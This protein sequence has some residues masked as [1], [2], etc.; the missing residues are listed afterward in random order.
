MRHTTILLLFLLILAAPEHFA[1]DN[2]ELESVALTIIGKNCLPCHNADQKTAGLVLD[3]REGALKGGNSGPALVPLHSADSLLIKK[4]MAGQMPPGN[5]LSIQDREILRQWVEAGA[6]WSEPLAKAPAKRPRGDMNWWAFQ[7]LGKP[8]VPNPSSIPN[9]WTHTAI[10]RFIYTKLRE[11]GLQPS[12]P[13]DRT[14]L[15]RRA[16]YDLLGLPPTPEEVDTFVNDNSPAAYEKLVDRL[17]NSP[18]YGERWGR[19]WLDVIRFGESQGYE[20][21]H[22][23]EQAWPFRDYIIKSFNQDKPFT[24]LIL[25]QLAGDQIAP[26]DPEIAVGTGFLVAGT[27]DTVTIENIEGKLQ[28]RANDLDDMVSTTGAAFL[29]VTIGC[30]RC[31]DHKFDP[32]QQ[33]DYYR[34]QAAFG[35]VQHGEREWTTLGL[36]ERRAAEEK[37]LLEKQQQVIAK[38]NALKEQARP[39]V[40]SQTDEITRRLRPA[41][42]SRG[43]E[44]TFPPVAARFVRMTILATTKNHPPALD[45]LEIWTSGPDPK[46]VA[47]ASYGTKAHARKTRTDEKDPNFYK[48]E[49]L[50]D[51]KA[52]EIW[53]SGEK[54][55]GEVTF[56]FPELE[57]ISRIT[58]S[59]DRP[60]ANQGK[61]VGYLPIHYTFE[62]STDGL[63]WQEISGSEDRLPYDEEERQELFILAVLPASD[64]AAWNTLK[65]EKAELQEALAALPP[66]SQAYIGTFEQPHEPAYLLKRGNPMDKGQVIPPGSLSTLERMLPG[67]QLDPNTPEGGRRLALAR[68]ISDE[69]NAL[70][71]RVL[72]NRVWHYHFG[73]G[74][75]GTPS[76][77]GFNGERPTHPELLEWLAG[78]LQE[79]GWRLKSLHREIMLSATYRQASAS[80]PEEAS[81]D[82]ESR[83]LWRYPPR[84]LEAEA[85]RDSILAV[86]GKLNTSMGGPGF[87]LYKYTV[88][89]VA[90][91]YPLENFD[92]SSFRRAVYQQTARS[93]KDDLLSLYDCPDSTVPDPKRVVTTTALQALSLL[94]STFIID[95]AKFFAERL[96]R[97]ASGSDV[98]GQVIRGFQLAFGRQP[99]TVELNKSVAF[100]QQDGLMAFCRILFNTNEFIYVM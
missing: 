26:D 21:N 41:V 60:G 40:E 47:L 49:F 33:A 48:V 23:R 82:N 85:V 84:R 37:P 22:L 99:T 92:P 6:P 24:Q 27:H 12:P 54:G 98:R 86:S 87:R 5:L 63:R 52:D 2:S 34:I 51:G 62:I 55:T 16:T 39:L 61:F 96:I 58:W 72:A 19:H 90:T 25:E 31:H 44:E 32:I 30:A 8:Q 68:W 36:K 88:D 46:N 13:A 11:K 83:Y 14:T 80:R 9:D 91:Y 76:D 15:I 97:E 89:N 7:P 71:A 74:L 69:R 70:T 42:S 17:L 4:I 57:T 20:Q 75:V 18:Q 73:K 29:G 38:L 100:I 78:R 28:Q 10:D 94:N 45:E 66:L 1:L 50:N 43:N 56:E 64:R 93:V 65:S 35:G 59:R 95:Q 81:I 53:I 77:F 79:L 67:Y 3:R